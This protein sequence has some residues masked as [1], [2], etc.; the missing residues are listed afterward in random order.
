MIIA[1]CGTEYLTYIFLSKKSKLFI[2]CFLL[3]L[4]MVSMSIEI[5]QKFIILPNKIIIVPIIVLFAVFISLVIL[6]FILPYL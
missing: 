4:L 2:P 1:F 6:K 5:M 3:F